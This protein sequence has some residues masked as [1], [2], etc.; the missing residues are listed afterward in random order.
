MK[1]SSSAIEGTFN[2]LTKIP[3]SGDEGIFIR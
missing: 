2:Y 3:S 1:A